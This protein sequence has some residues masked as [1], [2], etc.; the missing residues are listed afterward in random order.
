MINGKVTTMKTWKERVA[1]VGAWPCLWLPVIGTFGKSVLLQMFIGGA[2]PYAPDVWAGLC[3]VLPYLPLHA[4]VLWLIFGWGTLFC[5]RGRHIWNGVAG[6]LATFISFIDVAY[7]RAYSMLPSVS[8]LAMLGN[9]AGRNSIVDHWPTLINWWDALLVADMLLWAVLMIVCRPKP[10]RPRRRVSLISLGASALLLCIVP[11]LAVCGV[12]APYRRLHKTADTQQQAQY[13]SYL[14]FHLCDIAATTVG[15]QPQ[16]DA[17]DEALLAEFRAWQAE[18]AAVGPHTGLL[19][20]KNLMVIQVESLESF[21]LGQSIDGQEITPTINRLMTGGYT[22]PN[23]YEQVKGGNSSDCDF[24]LMTGL[25]PIDSNYVFN[26]HADQQYLSLQTLLKEHG[27]YTSHYFHG[28]TNSS[29]NYEDMLRNGIRVEHINSEYAQ[30]EILN[31]YVSDKSFF[32]QAAE[33]I[34]ASPMNEPFYAHITTCSSHVPFRLPE[35]L[36]E[37]KLDEK[38]ENNPMGRYLQVIR[39][40]DTQIGMFLEEMEKQGVLEN[41]VVVVVGDHGGV[42]KYYP[43]FVDDLDEDVR[44]DWFLER[45][46]KHTVPLIISCPSALPTKTVETIGGQVDVMPTLLGLLGV[47]DERLASVLFGRDLLATKRSFAVMSNGDVY[48][49]LPEEEAAI[50]KTAYYLSDL[51]VRSGRID[52]Q[53]EGYE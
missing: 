36:R 28:G 5:G 53:T 41:T 45:G 34:A 47:Q 44:E 40:T 29:W 42:N 13:F 43:H 19:A 1:A 24:L 33:K 10:K 32:R 20:G 35:E 3:R 23:I 22:F 17:Q 7:L 31:D 12:K 2:D 14:G 49:T 48:G 27:A 51:L 39:Y 38:L 16:F 6:G 8:M 15:Y 50:A 4:A 9:P 21:V 37:L 26:T 52:G 30:D 11:L 46:E 18:D 25:L